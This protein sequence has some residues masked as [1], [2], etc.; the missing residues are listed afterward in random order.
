MNGE[1]IHRHIYV[2]G[3]RTSV[4]LE[5]VFWET[6]RGI[7]RQQDVSVHYL[8]SVINRNRVASSLTSAIRT[9]VVTYLIAQ[10]PDEG[11]LSHHLQ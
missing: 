8:V 4:R 5:A 1:L 11:L 10:G 6:L 2:D 3:H 7:A 9:Y